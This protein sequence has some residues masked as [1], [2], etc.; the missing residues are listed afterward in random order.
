MRE[1]R[2]GGKSEGP[3]PAGEE[4][5]QSSLV[6]V[7]ITSLVAVFR[8]F[9]FDECLVSESDILDGLVRSLL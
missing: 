7:A 5:R 6:I 9:D 3:A 8:H 2:L 4:G 1:G